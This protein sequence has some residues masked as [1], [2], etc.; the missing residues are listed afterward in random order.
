MKLQLTITDP[1]KTHPKKHIRKKKKTCVCSQKMKEKKELEFTFTQRLAFC[2][3]EVVVVVTS[4]S[5]A[6]WCSQVS[7]CRG[8]GST[9]E[10]TDKAPGL[11]T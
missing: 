6:D 10:E 2:S 7:S 11:C 5:L 3:L 8:R 4:P 9:G 1:V